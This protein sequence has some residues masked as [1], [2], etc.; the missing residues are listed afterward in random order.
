MA[1]REQMMKALRNAHEAGDT[2]AAT[3]IAAMIKAAPAEAAPQGAVP[4]QEAPQA[5]VGDTL[6][7]AGRIVAGVPVSLANAGLGVLNTI[8]E[9]VQRASNAITGETG[10][11]TPIAKAG[12]GSLDSVLAPRGNEQIGSDIGAALITAPVMGAEMVA[13]QGAGVLSRLAVGAGRNAA[14]AVVPVMAQHESGKESTEALKDIAL[15]TAGGMALEGVAGQVLKRV[16]KP[17]EA[18]RAADVVSDQHL[19]NV[20]QGGNQEAQQAYRTGTTDEAGNSLLNPSQV[21]NTEGGA[22]YIAAEQ[23]DLA[24]GSGSQYAQNLAAQRE[25]GAVARA[26]DQADT[27]AD[28][29]QAAGETVDA[30]KER[31]KNLYNTSKTDAQNILDSANVSKIKLPETKQ[32]ANSHLEANTAAGNINLNAETR[33]TLTQLNKADFNNI[34][35]LD[36]WKRTLSEKSQKAYRNGD[37]T[38]SNALREVLNTLRNEADRTVSSINPEAGSVYRDADSYFSSMAGDFGKKSPLSR[39][40]SAD[41]SVKAENVMLGA[42]SAVGREAGANN[43]AGILDAVSQAEQAGNLPEGLGAQLREALGNTTRSRALAEANSGEN[44]SPTKF[45][46]RLSQYDTQATAA[47][48]QEVNNAL[49]S[50]IDT[51]R[52][53]NAVTTPVRDLLS[54]VAGR[55]VGGAVGATVGGVPGAFIGQGV[56]GK[57]S[58]FIN[59]SVIDRLMGTTRNAQKIIDFVSDPRNAQ[60]VQDVLTSRNYSGFNNAPAVEIESAVNQVQRSMNAGY[61]SDNQQTAEQPTFTNDNYSPVTNDAP[62]RAQS[63]STPAFEPKVTKLYKALAHAET[64]GLDNRFIRTKAAES[65]VST[66]YGPAQLT[67]STLDDF[68]KRHPKMFS[69]QEQ[70]YIQRFSEQGHKMKSARS[71]DPVYGYGGKGVLNSK[72]DQRLYAVVVRKMLQQMVKENGGSLDKTVKHWRGNDNDHAYFAKVLKAYK[73]S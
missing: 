30:F 18:S 44:F 60:A 52:T 69:A 2:E 13:D 12:Y 45:T 42:N 50:V 4:P 8:G 67:V 70:D 57:V 28:L 29:Q 15:N 53:Q 62:Q 41:N 1:S 68:Y 14:G 64:G 33:R 19:E 17:S 9:G 3:R 6:A 61:H 20:L 5:T 49:R 58:S 65:G 32:V 43:T 66:A 54:N 72:A 39:L 23:R 71:D 48:Q 55:A 51:A 38:S 59:S 63:V 31:A 10:E 11:Y 21:F 46:N 37:F 7:G 34:D 47:G 22:K 56:G 16:V 35:T 25:G 73:G 40:A 27:G 24:R 36:N 26:V